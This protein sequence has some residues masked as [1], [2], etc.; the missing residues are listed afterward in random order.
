V[1]TQLIQ[2]PNVT[3]YTTVNDRGLC[4][5][6]TAPRADGWL[7]IQLMPPDAV[8]GRCARLGRDIARVTDA[9]RERRSASPEEAG[10]A[11]GTVAKIGRAF[12]SDV[13]RDPYDDFGQLS[14]FLRAACPTWHNRE[15]AT[16]LIHAV[17]ETDQYFPWELLPLFD[18][19]AT[20]EV[21][22][23]LELE[24]AS[25]T[26]PG[27][28]AIVERQD[29]DHVADG[30]FLDGW[31]PLP[32]RVVY[33]ASY[34]GAQEEVGF[35]RGKGDLFRLKGPYPRDVGD[36]QAPTLASQLWD[37]ALGVDGKRDDSPDQVI[38]FAC[39]C[40]AVAG[41]DANFAYRLADEQGRRMVVRL[42]DLTDE[43]MRHSAVTALLPG[44]ERR[45]DKP[46]VFL[47]ACGT[48]VMDPACAI[49]LLK[50]FRDNR[51]RGIIGTVANVPDRI[52][53][54]LSRWFYTN[55]LVRGADVGHS[56]HEAKWR[57]LQDRGNPLGLLY[58]LHAFAG[59]RLAPVP[60]YAEPT[61][62]GVS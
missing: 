47:N 46:L 9:F 20:I 3:A 25:L 51:N 43:L 17:A 44:P 59:L 2:Q 5:R 7:S 53:A 1:D 61:I 10:R 41:D 29:P 37:P 12:L 38:H 60:A 27:F 31:D 30:P 49:S 42:E 28:A 56:L 24:Q 40:D 55:L 8:R 26:F 35:F 50:P 39:H 57:L 22:D 62:G 13:L 11:L 32:I 19:V 34:S 16:P 52:A 23:Q 14:R 6:L 21:R 4:L 45:R 15:A 48:A 54:E 33:D 36:D 18:P 58:S